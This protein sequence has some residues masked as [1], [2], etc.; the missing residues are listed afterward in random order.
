MLD[1]E[2]RKE[3]FFDCMIIL[4]TNGLKINTGFK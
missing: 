2:G 1:E 4:I 3:I